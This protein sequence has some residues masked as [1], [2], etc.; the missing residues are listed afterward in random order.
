MTCNLVLQQKQFQGALAHDVV[1]R[2]PWTAGWWR[3]TR[4]FP[5]LFITVNWLQVLQNDPTS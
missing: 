4:T 3:S 1:E 5:W 2:S